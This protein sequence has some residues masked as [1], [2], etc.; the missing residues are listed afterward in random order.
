MMKAIGLNEYGNPEVMQVMELEKPVPGKNQVLIKVQ[1]VSVN[2]ADLLKRSGYYHNDSVA[3]PVIPGLDAMGVIEAVGSDV[4]GLSVG[5]RVVAFPHTGTYTEY[6]LADDDLAYVV[7]D[8]ISFEQAAACPLVAFTSYNLLHKAGQLK[9]G[10]TVVIHAASGG[11][12]TTAVQM[13]KGLEAQ[14]IGTIG[15]KADSEE[16]V[17]VAL[18]AGCD[19]VIN[20]SKED[21]VARV[22]EITNNKGADVILDSLGGEYTSRG[23]NCLAKYGRMVVFG[24]ASGS[25]ADL[26]TNLLHSSCRS[27]VGYSSITTRGEKPSWFVESAPEIFKLMASGQVKMKV[28]QVFDIEEAA[29]AHALMESGGTSGKIILKF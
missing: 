3:F 13:A 7:P 24:N 25:Y 22:N 11:I 20:H 2:F 26:G 23:M 29:K 10:E 18:E 14:V 27:I 1:G 6:V 5:Q 28:S 21:F 8:E 15:S 4:K 9:A 19:F 17:A 12:G 16:S